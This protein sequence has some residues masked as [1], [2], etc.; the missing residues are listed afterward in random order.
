MIML[1]GA[2]FGDGHHRR[3]DDR[4]GATTLAG[5]ENDHATMWRTGC[6]RH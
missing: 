2:G 1:V 4:T 3:R 5:G 6:G